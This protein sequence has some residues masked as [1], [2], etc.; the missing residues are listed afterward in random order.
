MNIGEGSPSFIV[1]L[2]PTLD[3]FV[4]HKCS[5]RRC[6][7]CPS[8]STSTKF[9]SNV[10]NKMHTI[11]NPTGDDL[12]CHSQ[13]IIYLLSCATCN[14]QYV[15]ETACPMHLRM[16]QHRTSK[17][18][19]EHVINH[20]T[21]LCNGHRFHYQIIEKLPGTGYTNGELD[22][23]MT[24]I[25]KEHENDWI[26]RLRTIFPYGLNEKADGKETN[27]SIIHHA[28]G[29]LFPPIPRSGERP[30]RSRSNK[31]NRIPI[32]SIS[33]FFTQLN[34]YILV[35]TKNSFNNIRILLNRSKKKLLKEI[36]HSLI[37]RDNFTYVE[38]REQWYLYISDI[39]DTLLLKNVAPQKKVHREN[40]CIIHFC[41]KGFNK[42]GLSKI[43]RNT[44]VVA[45]L[46]TELQE[47]FKVP[48]PTYKLDA[49]IRNKILNYKEAVNS[50]TI[51]LE[52][53]SLIHNLPSCECPGSSFCDPHHKHIVTGDLSIIE[54]PKLRS[55]FSKGP[56]Y[57]EPKQF[58]LDKCK[59]SIIIALDET[60]SKL[61]EKYKLDRS[62]FINWSNT[63]LRKIDTSIASL[64]SKITPQSTSVVLKDQTVLTYLQEL[65]KKFVIVPI[66]KAS[67]N[68]A[69]VCKRFYIES[70]FDELGIPGNSS[71][72][73][74]LVSK[75]AESIIDDND[76]L[77]NSILGNK[78]DESFRS[79]PL[80]YW[81]PKMHYT[82]CRKRFIIASAQCSTKPLTKVMSKIFRHIFNQIQTFHHK[83]TFY[84]NY[85][86]FWVIQNSFPVLNKIHEI[87][88]KKKARE[89][90]AFDFSTLYTK[91]PHDDLIRVLNE[92]VDF[93][94]NGGKFKRNGNRKFLTLFSNSSYWTKKSHGL[95][96]FSKNKI[97]RL[98]THLIKQCHF[99]FANLVLKQVIGIPMGIDPAPF[100]ANLY[101]HYYEDKHV[102]TIMKTDAARARLYKYSTRF[103][104]D[105][106]NL[107]DSGQ[108]KASCQSIY[109]PELQVKC[110]HE[111][112][113]ATFLELDITIENGMFVYR[114]FDK[115]DNFPFSIIRMPD[116][117]GNIP[118]HVFY[119]SVMSE[120]LRIARATLLYHDFVH[121]AKELFIRMIRQSGDRHM[122]LL[123]LKKAIN[124]HTTIFK[125]YHKSTRDIL[126][127]VCN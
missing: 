103:I 64:R 86:K 31:N 5:D 106:C 32:L 13:N 85:N 6:K 19:C 2:G 105:Q 14:I 107:N 42:L 92:M 83:C 9:R 77:V 126:N 110:E 115:R 50:I 26:K 27:S 11:V 69:I 78:L 91:L 118:D 68:V 3:R 57:R 48:F 62:S 15:G 39:I 72:T 35:D 59:Q 89:I 44:D 58:N 96:S 81:M 70:I 53:A 33:D 75:S 22:E 4:L 55:L 99:Q 43:F 10:T 16:N 63:I 54:D 116:L 84:K 7:T 29:K 79:L 101:L 76:H 17:C 71:S 90:S 36:A 20:S 52:D 94:F 46:P 127:D 98:L 124:K 87:N 111:G 21:E 47:E 66:D 97:K 109:P 51:D 8:F 119:G 37:E 122:L 95:I 1:A 65:H 102:S 104:D 25:R 28:V 30:I 49:P 120:F 61:S 113:H 114:L 100:W 125:K 93:A 41:N 24:K 45:S 12:N 112:Q 121:K 67:L 74:K 40:P 117:S 56:G 23:G 82:P 123:Q 38:G 34:S 88:A 108:F 60:I 80:I 18:G 73:Y